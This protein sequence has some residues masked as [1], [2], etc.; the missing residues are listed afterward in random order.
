MT[1]WPNMVRHQPAKLAIRVQVPVPSPRSV[2]CFTSWASHALTAAKPMSLS[3]ISVPKTSVVIHAVCAASIQD[4]RPGNRRIKAGLSMS[5]VAN[6]VYV[7]IA[8]AKTRLLSIILE[9]KIRH[10][11]A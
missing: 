6:V 1:G 11:I 3:F 9:K 7:G 10:S 8:S 5:W 4:V 2:V